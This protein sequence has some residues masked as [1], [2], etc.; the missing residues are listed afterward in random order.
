MNKTILTTESVTYAIK[1]KRLLS[2]SGIQSKLIKV[3]P[4]I[5]RNGCTH[6][7]LINNRD[8]LSA[9]KVLRDNEINYSVIERNGKYDIP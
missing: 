1:A 7:I 5:K 6:G 8:F 4:S 2:Y 9:V 3:D